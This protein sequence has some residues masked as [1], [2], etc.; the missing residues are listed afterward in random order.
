MVTV[1]PS[2]VSHDSLT[3]T[4]R[5]VPLAVSKTFPS[6]PISVALSSVVGAPC[7]YGIENVATVPCCTKGG[8]RHNAATQASTL[9]T[10]WSLT[11]VGASMVMGAPSEICEHGRGEH[12]EAAIILTTVA[13]MVIVADGRITTSN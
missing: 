9:T 8:V 4:P 7:G 5:T 6:F 11:I 3:F 12:A 13:M 2:T 10:G 1:A